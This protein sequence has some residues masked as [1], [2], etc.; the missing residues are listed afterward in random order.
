VIEN[1]E[2]PEI[3]AELGRYYRDGKMDGFCMYLYALIL[4]AMQKSKLRQD[5]QHNVLLAGIEQRASSSLNQSMIDPEND[6]LHVN[7]SV[8]EDG[9]VESEAF[10]RAMMI[11]S[12]RAYPWNWIAWT[13]LTRTIKDAVML[14]RIEPLLP[15]HLLKRF[16]Y[17]EAQLQIHR[18][19]LA[20]E[21]YLKLYSQFPNN[22]YLKS[23]IA[24]VHHNLRNADPAL[25]LFE[26]VREEDPF[27]LESMDI[28]SNVLYIKDDR[29]S[30]RYLAHHANLIDK[31]SPQTCCIVGNFYS[32]S[33]E[34]NKAII[35]YLR[36][37]KLDPSYIDAWT[38]VGHEYIQLKDTHHAIAAY[39]RAVDSDPSAYRAWY[40]LG[41]AYELLYMPQY[42]LYYYEHAAEL[43]P[44]DSRM[45]CALGAC[46]EVM[47]QLNN[48]LLCYHRAEANQDKEGNIL[49][50]LAEVYK[51]LGR[52]DEAAAYYTRNLNQ[53]ERD[54]PNPQHIITALHF[55]A[56]YYKDLDNY[57]Q[58][59][60]YCSRLV[61]FSG[62]EK[63][64][65]KALMR[66]MSASAAYHLHQ[67]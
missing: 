20:L 4:R 13:E 63:E 49:H 46:Y 15:D 41:Q 40:G 47:G 53:N 64:E 59:I 44:H 48:T 21:S 52:R 62:P 45:W 5:S 54:S 17:A 38:L 66:E 1:A 10:Q 26:Q 29:A 37:L 56:H 57:Q 25:E 32:L 23:Q 55:L 65:I 58:A 12:I 9:M 24:I 11:S 43:R 22:T 16:W 61:D 33:G 7:E 14:K 42:A 8:I 31:Y 6:E 51:K 3:H 19:E 18:D 30:L 27:R 34:H 60:Q 2:L 67:S 50:L 28:Y 36:A 39:R 35:Y